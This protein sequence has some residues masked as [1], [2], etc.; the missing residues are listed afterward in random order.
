MSLLECLC[1]TRA[2]YARGKE[3]DWLKIRGGKEKDWLKYGG[4]KRE[5]LAKKE[6]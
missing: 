2:H 4:R 5:R 6:K 3:K 1:T